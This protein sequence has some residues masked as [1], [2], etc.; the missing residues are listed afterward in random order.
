MLQAHSVR[1]AIQ[2]L[3][4]FFTS[5]RRWLM[6]AVVLLAAVSF[7]LIERSAAVAQNPQP[8]D[9]RSS[10][11]NEADA[12]APDALATAYGANLATQSEV[13]ATPQPQLAGRT[14][15]VNGRPA[16]LLYVSPD[17]INF[18]VPA[19]AQPGPNTVTV[20]AANG[21]TVATGA[22]N[23]NAVAPALFTAGNVVAGFALR[24]KSDGAQGY[25]PIAE[26]DQTSNRFKP[27]AIDP[28][29]AG[30]QVFL[31]MFLSGI[32]HADPAQVRVL[33]GSDQLEPVYAGASGYPGL[34]QINLALS[35]ELRGRG[36]LTLAVK[37]SVGPTSNLAEV[38]IGGGG[39][40]VTVNRFSKDRVQVGE[41]VEIF[42]ANFPTANVE[43]LFGPD[44]VSRPD[45]ATPDKLTVRVPPARRPAPSASASTKWRWASAVV[46]CGSG[47]RSAA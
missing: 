29:A 2:P 14:V 15:E 20:R 43:V 19:G 44:A 7:G 47:P 45:L 30:D 36:K 40:A 38:E 12:L 37:A 33:L 10:A 22:T 31:V 4:Q 16:M 9:I 25:E 5:R 28:G 24:V 42:G 1:I 27:K 39:A 21:A 17:Q 6:L 41:T 32:R 18:L 26:F 34:D 13:A 3:R 23:I 46:L 11:S 35:A 8:L